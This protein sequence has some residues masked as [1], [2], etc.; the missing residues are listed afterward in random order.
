[1]VNRIWFPNTTKMRSLERM[2]A[3]HLNWFFHA[4]LLFIQCK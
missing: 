3:W 4:L 1:M 2:L